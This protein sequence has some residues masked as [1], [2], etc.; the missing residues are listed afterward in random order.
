M[1]N[2]YKKSAL[3]GSRTPNLPDLQSGCSIQ[4]SYISTTIMVHLKGVEPLTS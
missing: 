2:D 4:L 1:T 3:E